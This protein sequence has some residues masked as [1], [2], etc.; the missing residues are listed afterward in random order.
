ME[1]QQP[2]RN[3][4]NELNVASNSG[5]LNLNK[6]KQIKLKINEYNKVRKDGQ[7]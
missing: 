7:R 5:A 1:N 2:Y 4:F 3:V 6:I